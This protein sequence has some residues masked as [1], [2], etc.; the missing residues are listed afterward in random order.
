MSPLPYTPVVRAGPWLIV[1]GQVGLREGTLVP[2][3]VRPEAEQ[4]LA[5]L[6]ARLADNGASLADV[7]K[8]TVFMTDIADFSDI[9]EVYAKAFGDHFPARSAVAVAALPMGACFEVE[10]WA[11]CPGP[12]P[13]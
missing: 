13:G 3:G 5:N 6:A 4:A 10:A 1:S 9:N 7:A 12:L 2:G 11:Y 8:T